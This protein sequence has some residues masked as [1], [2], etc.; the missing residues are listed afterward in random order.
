[1]ELILAA[2][3]AKFIHSSLAIRCLKAAAGPWKDRIQTA[4]YTINQDPDFILDDLYQKQPRAVGFSCYLWNI[5]L[6]EMLAENLKKLLPHLQIFLGGPEVS[7]DAETVLRQNPAVDFIIRG[8][9]EGVFRAY[10]DQFFGQNMAYRHLSGITWRRED[11]AI[12]E[13]PAHPPMDLSLI[14]FPYGDEPL[15]AHRILYYETQRGCPYQCQYCLSSLEK[16]VRFL[17]EHRVQQELQF[18]LDQRV[19]QVKFV[20]RTFN[21]NP[22][23][24]MMIWR[25]LIDHD[26]GVTN[27]HMEITADLL[28]Q[29]M[30]D[31]LGTARPGLFQFEIGVQST[32]PDTIAAIKRNTS[33]A[34]LTQKV[35]ALQKAH[36]IH[37]HLDLIAGLPLED[38]DSF[39]RSFDDVYRLN[40][41][42]F[43]LGFLKL[44]K[45]SG[46]RQDAE[47][48][49]IVYRRQPVYEVLY[50]KDLPYEQV[51]KLKLVEEMV[52][53]YYN[54][55]KAFYTLRF[56][57][58]F[59]SSAFH[60]FQALG[61]FWE[62]Q[63]GKE[64]KFS[65]LDQVRLFWDFVSTLPLSASQ[66]ETA[67]ELLRFD[68]LLAHNEKRIPEAL[69]PHP[70]GSKEELRALAKQLGIASKEPIHFERFTVNVCDLAKDANTKVVFAPTQV[71][72][73]YGHRDAIHKRA[74]IQQIP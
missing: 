70:A 65:K 67:R 10:L 60:L 19:P 41:D 9:G 63:G 20:D 52:E 56:L 31:L 43:Q 13:N 18:F 64:L 17:P 59:L 33:F 26:N 36:N 73:R 40:P 69:A 14:P 32:N 46:L 48:F 8:E 28:T 66:R 62:S 49:G 25:Y 72:F 21:C 30:I 39:A 54:S 11:G 2:I 27:F 12:I 24:A 68:L 6:I 34:L 1:M 3:N 45:G 61:F 47:K 35:Q 71:L 50:T 53:T 38:Y 51:R 55:P 37:I 57:T 7:Y 23:H 42:Q 22:R 5:T 58:S 29:E 44:L 4:E 74:Q 15:P 16:G